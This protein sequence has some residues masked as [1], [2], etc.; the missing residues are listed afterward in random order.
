MQAHTGATM[1]VIQ[2][3]RSEVMADPTKFAGRSFYVRTTMPHKEKYHQIKALEYNPVTKVMKFEVGKDW[4]CYMQVRHNYKW[5][6]FEVIEHRHTYVRERFKLYPGTRLEGEYR[7]ERGINHR[8]DGRILSAKRVECFDYFAD[9][10][11]PTGK[12]LFRYDFEIIDEW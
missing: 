12:R 1:V 4:A 5:D 11:S 9:V 2:K 10:K 3:L 8:I 7:S 6:E